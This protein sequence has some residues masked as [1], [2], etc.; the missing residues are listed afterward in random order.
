MAMKKREKIMAGVTIG[1]VVV[2][3][4]MM[5]SRGGGTSVGKLRRDQADLQKKVDAL[6]EQVRP[7]REA[8]E[9]LE[10]WRESSLPA[11][12]AHARDLYQS[13]LVL[14]VTRV[15]GKADITPGSPAQRKAYTMLRFKVESQGSLKQ[16]TQFLYEFYS[17]N[18]LHKLSL[19]TVKPAEGASGQFKLVM[20]IEALC[21]EEAESTTELPTGRSPRLEYTE[22]DEYL[23][24][25]LSRRMEGDRT[26]DGVGLFASYEPAPPRRPVVERP[27]VERPVVERPVQQPRQEFDHS[28]QTFVNAIQEIDGL[29]EVWLFTRTSGETQQLH[30]GDRFRVGSLSGTVAKIRVDERD[31][32]IETEDGSR[33]VALGKRLREPA[34]TASFMMQPGSMPRLGGQPGEMS[35]LGEVVGGIVDTLRGFTTRGGGPQGDAPTGR[36][37]S[38]SGS[39][40]DPWGGFFSS[41][42]Q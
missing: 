9:R 31:I 37:G 19:L 14:T 4:V 23:R 40:E 28:E 12:Y 20:N 42:S 16:L 21:L 34:Q 11:D 17:A 3:V 22:L 29:K 36:S 25:I 15:L 10:R 33:Y 30:E 32:E 5:V 26:V 27:V 24:G 6:K 2:I 38:G 18:Y 39:G 41:E 1:L 8:A 35:N 7:G 13:W